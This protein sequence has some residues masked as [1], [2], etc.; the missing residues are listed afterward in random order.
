MGF[1]RPCTSCSSRHSSWRC[2]LRHALRLCLPSPTRYSFVLM[3]LKRKPNARCLVCFRWS[4]RLGVTKYEIRSSY[5]QRTQRAGDW[6]KLINIVVQMR[7]CLLTH[8]TSHVF[9]CPCPRG[10]NRRPLFHS[11]WS[12][13][14]Q[15][16][17]IFG[18][19]I[20]LI[21]CVWSCVFSIV[22]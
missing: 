16:G 20:F 4:F 15:M 3:E 2:L 1:I 8:V 19:I 18:Q 13:A 6:Q 21:P 7:V 10:L 9:V 5:W 22:T 14:V 11:S 12:G 17:R